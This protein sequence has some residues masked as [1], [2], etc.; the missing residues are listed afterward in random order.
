MI[1]V[2][3]KP[4]L[5]RETVN[6]VEVVVHCKQEVQWS[7]TVTLSRVLSRKVTCGRSGLGGNELVML[8]EKWKDGLL[9]T[10][11]KSIVRKGSFIT[12]A[13]TN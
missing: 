6:H 8:L 10:R 3:H 5:V 2:Y 11:S 7:Y 1:K 9:R 4:L 12:N 13:N